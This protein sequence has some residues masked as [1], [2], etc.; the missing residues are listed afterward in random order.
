MALFL[1]LLSVIAVI[2]FGGG[3]A[4]VSFDKMNSELKLN[5]NFGAGLEM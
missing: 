5:F 1:D 2:A 4:Q 3:G